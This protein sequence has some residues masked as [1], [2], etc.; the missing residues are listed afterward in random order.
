MAW[1]EYGAT[2]SE[3]TSILKLDLDCILLCL[4]HNGLKTILAEANIVTR[5]HCF[6][7]VEVIDLDY[8]VLAAASV[9]LIG[10][11][12]S[13]LTHIVMDSFCR[14]RSGTTS[15]FSSFDIED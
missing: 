10:S 1:D 6:G 11:D 4:E 9:K 12:T 5:S 7:N 3:N 2:W 13:R 8:T 14:L 15:N